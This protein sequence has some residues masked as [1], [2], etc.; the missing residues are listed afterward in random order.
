[1]NECVLK[2]MFIVCIISL[3]ATIILHRTGRD[4]VLTFFMAIFTII[5]TMVTIFTTLNVR[6]ITNIQFINDSIIL[7][8]GESQLLQIAVEPKDADEKK[9][10]W[11]SNDPSIVTVDESGVINAISKGNA[12]ITVEA[13]KCSAACEVTVKNSIMSIQLEEE[14]IDLNVGESQTLQFVFEPD[15]ADEQMLSWESSD[16]NIVAVDENG[17][18]NAISKGEATVTVEAGNCSASC[19][20]T[21]KNPL[22]GIQLEKQ[23]IDLDV[24]ESRILQ[25]VFDPIDA[26]EQMLSWESSDSNIVAVDENGTINAISKGEATVTVEAGNCSASCIVT[27]KNPLKGIQLEKQSI[28]LDV[29]ESQILQVV[30]DPIDA[31]EQ[32]LSWISSDTSIVTV[33]GNGSIKAIGVG[34]AVISVK[35]GEFSDTCTV[36]VVADKSDGFV[37]NDTYYSYD[38]KISFPSTEHQNSVKMKFIGVD[39]TGWEVTIGIAD[40]PFGVTLVKEY[41]EEIQFKVSSGTYSIQVFNND[42]EN[43]RVYNNIVEIDSDREYIVDL[44]KAQI[45]DH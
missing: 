19:I 26:D 8:V 11:E 45:T 43:Q 34:T 27:V 17:T 2:V 16:S 30:F 32:I 40:G 39:A 12:T 14:S 5:S 28:D 31:D 4:R 23:I 36:T 21:V 20:V 10:S 15:D 6:K 3:I 35:A 22:K 44:T 37:L 1:M 18:I 41:S 42:E 29:G 38:G 9:L 25:V 13:D 33:N 24:G 7:N